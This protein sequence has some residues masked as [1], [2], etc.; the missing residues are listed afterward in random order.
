MYPNVEGALEGAHD[1]D[2]GD[3]WGEE[4]LCEAGDVADEGAGVECHQEEEHDAGPDAN[5][6]PG[7]SKNSPGELI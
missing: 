1:E 5:P 2:E 6:Q 3:E 4:L 7:I